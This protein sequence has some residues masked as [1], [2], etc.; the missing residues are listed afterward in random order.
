MTALSRT[1]KHLLALAALVALAAV[2]SVTP[3]PAVAQTSS[4][5]GGAMPPVL[6]L[7]GFSP[8]GSCPGA[9]RS[10]WSAL[11]TGLRS[12]GWT[13]IHKLQFYACDDVGGEFIDV[14]GGHVATTPGRTWA[15]SPTSG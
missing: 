14:D 11:E 3:L 6:L 5:R 1:Y 15:I 9:P 12:H 8:F 10:Q 7:H 13:D 2:A 4:P